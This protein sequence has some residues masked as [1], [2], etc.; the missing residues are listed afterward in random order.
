M[1]RQGFT[2][3]EV[4]VAVTLLS[5]LFVLGIVNYI[6]FEERQRLIQAAQLVR[7]V[8]VDA[9]N[10]ARSGKL[11]GCSML[12]SYRVSFVESA[13]TLAPECREGDPAADA[14]R[15]HS[16][17][18]QVQFDEEV[19]LYSLALSGLIASTPT[20]FDNDQNETVLPAN[21]PAVIEISNNQGTIMVTVQGTGAVEI[22]DI[23]KQ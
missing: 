17:P 3:I 6:N 15:T 14:T 13:I 8:V 22:S 9:Q 16:L 11:R 23:V 1:N 19:T 20:G 21:S 5:L 4:L 12:Y 10:S 18:N 7:E 2:L